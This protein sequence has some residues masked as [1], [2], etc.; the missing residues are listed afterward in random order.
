MAN[1]ESLRRGPLV[2]VLAALASGDVGS[3]ALVRA[4]LE[5]IERDAALNAWTHVDADGAG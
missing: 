5:A 4:S 1:V 2:R 3:E